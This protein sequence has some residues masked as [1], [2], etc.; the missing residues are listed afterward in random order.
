[1]SANQAQETCVFNRITGQ[2][3]TQ[4]VIPNRVNYRNKLIDLFVTG[5][6]S[7]GYADIYVGS[8]V[9]M[10]FPF[11]VANTLLISSPSIKYDG[12]GGFGYFIKKILRDESLFPNAAEDEEIVINLSAPATEIDAYYLQCQGGDVTSHNVPG[13]SD[14]NIKPFIDIFTYT[15]TSAGAGQM[16]TNEVVPT[17]LA[18][19]DS[20]RRISPTKQFVLYSLVAD[21]V[22]SGSNYTTYNRLHIYDE[23]NE[24]FT[25]LDHSGLNINIPNGTNDIN[26]NFST[27]N[28]FA[29]NPPYTFNPNHLVTLLTDVSN[30]SGN[31]STLYVYLLGIKK[32]LSGGG[33]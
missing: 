20:N 22:S 25:P 6:P 30:I 10:R 8:R 15:A 21:Y 31:G 19:L 26:Y 27:N 13:G 2:S 9:Y 33:G 5:A 1:M 18:L 23:E 29:V 7:G 3:T 17:G 16:I 28:Y 11:Q 4:L 24:L 32:T 12:L 14:Y